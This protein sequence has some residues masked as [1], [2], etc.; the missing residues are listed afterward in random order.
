MILLAI[1]ASAVF[2]VISPP[3]PP[4]SSRTPRRPA[5]TTARATPRSTVSATVKSAASPAKA[6]EPG[7]Y[8]N[9]HA[10]VSGNMNIRQSPSTSAAILGSTPPGERYT[11]V[12]S[13]Q[14][15]IYCWLDIDLGWIAVTEFV[16]AN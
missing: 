7:C 11:V 5:A 4:P 2:A 14:G 9:S 13:R 16:S 6:S 1:A 15:D 3:D 10:W 12:A 8:R